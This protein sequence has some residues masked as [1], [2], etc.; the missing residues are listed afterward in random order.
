M[1]Y[2][3]I[4]MAMVTVSFLSV[5][6]AKNLSQFTS[7]K[8]E[9]CIVKNM[10]TETSEIDF[11]DAVC[12][13]YA[14]YE[15]SVSGGDLRYN[16]KL[17]YNG[18][19]IKTEDAGGAFHDLS[20][21]KVEWRY[22]LKQ[23]KLPWNTELSYTAIIYTIGYS[24][25]DQEGNQVNDDIVVVIKLDGEKSCQT[26]RLVKSKT[27]NAMEAARKIADSPKAKCL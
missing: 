26:G 5:S 9:D 12:S 27:K 24:S 2:K 21:D 10:S 3:I 8:L 19:D 17:K 14:G 16:L 6:N 23:T 7:V 22:S 18:V 1:I 11:Y 4:F 25:Y 13:S 15:V 20:S